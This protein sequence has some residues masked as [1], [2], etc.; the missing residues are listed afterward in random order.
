MN[1]RIIEFISCFEWNIS[2]VVCPVEQWKQNSFEFQDA[3]L[4][5][6]SASIS[7]FKNV[8]EYA[9]FKL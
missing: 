1:V 6:K 7:S 4:Y 3:D 9:F 2:R 5:R 8:A